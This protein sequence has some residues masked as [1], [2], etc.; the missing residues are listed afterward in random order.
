MNFKAN[1]RVVHDIYGIGTVQIAGV[2]RWCRV[3][4]DNGTIAIVKTNELAKYFEV[5]K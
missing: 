4:F 2:N 5:K 3:A 1:D